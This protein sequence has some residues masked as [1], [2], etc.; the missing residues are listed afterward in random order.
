MINPEGTEVNFFWVDSW[1]SRLTRLS[2]DAPF[3]LRRRQV[4]A[5]LGVSGKMIFSTVPRLTEVA[6]PLFPFDSPEN[7]LLSLLLAK[8]QQRF[9]FFPPL[10]SSTPF[11][12][13][14]FSTFSR[15]LIPPS[16]LC[17]FF[18][19]FASGSC[20][21]PP[22]NVTLRPFLFFF[23][24]SFRLFFFVRVFSPPSPPFPFPP[25]KRFR[26][27][28]SPLGS[29]P[30]CSLQVQTVLPFLLSFFQASLAVARLIVPKSLFR[31]SDRALPLQGPAP[32]GES[33]ACVGT[34]LTVFFLSGHIQRYLSP[35]MDLRAEVFS[36]K[37]PAAG[38]PRFPAF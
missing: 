5:L 32:R 14:L 1:V 9:F 10:L 18:P 28:F 16:Q 27:P 25:K 6:P 31:R 23:F 2:L 29:C 4:V 20:A 30:P 35:P 22:G 21:I 3:F 15:V 33:N 11:K 19:L 17:D 13:E 36:S 12:V 8:G 7:P 26:V 37:P 38:V 34:L 24:F